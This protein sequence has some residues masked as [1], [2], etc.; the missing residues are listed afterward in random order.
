[1]GHN[2]CSEET[3]FLLTRQPVFD[4]SLEPWGSAMRFALPGNEGHLFC[5]ETS[6]N[7][8]LEAYLPQ[9]EDSTSRILIG[10]PE[11]ALLQDIPRLLWPE[12]VVLEV[13]E[14]AGFRPGIVQA[15]A[16]LKKVGFG[17]AISDFRNRPGCGGLNALAE[18]MGID[19]ADGAES[20]HGNLEERIQAA[21]G[22]GAKA[23][24]RGLTS[25]TPMLQ[26][27]MANAD[28]FQGFFFTSMHLKPSSRL[29]TAT[30]VSRLRLLECLSQPD[31]DFKA[32]ARVVEADAALTYRLLLFL[33]SA[34]FGLARKVTSIEQAIVLAGWRPLK[35]WLEI[36]LLTD[37]SPSPRHQEL[38]HYAAQ[39]SIFLRCI[40]KTA[41]LEQLAPSLALLGL[42][43]FIEPILEMPPEQA[44]VNIPVSEA[45]RM[46][47]CGQKSPLSPWLGL[48]Y[49][50][51][52]AQWEL[53]ARVGASVKLALSDLS[54]CYLESLTEADALFRL[55]PA[56]K[57][58]ASNPDA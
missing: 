52:N 19:C 28:F 16:E 39:R 58:K 17:I 49:A 50:M 57:T 41:G 31:A 47:L 38:C 32:L 25:W 7:M 29:I 6:A 54:K 2:T 4:R 45:I 5:D 33:N 36:A 18:I 55:L 11:E 40:A 15:V 26:A 27:R 43:S 20:D 22:L 8:L 42:L 44:L 35:K 21:H 34:S 12:G 56:P 14:S 3:G 13:D 46:A 23:L 9:R 1:M 51:E 30:Q 48:A 53:A 10:F 37:L 24:V